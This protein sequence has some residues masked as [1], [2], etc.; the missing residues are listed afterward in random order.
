MEYTNIL[1]EHWGKK[2]VGIVCDY[3]DKFADE[4]V[5]TLEDGTSI[6]FYHQQ[7]CCECVCIEDIDIDPQELVGSVLVSMEEAYNQEFDDCDESQTWTFYNIQTNN[8][9]ATIRWWGTSNGYYSESVHIS[10]THASD[11]DDED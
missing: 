6:K 8:T 1:S 5:L 4:L 9:C 10:V 3:P 11:V 2:I 7:D